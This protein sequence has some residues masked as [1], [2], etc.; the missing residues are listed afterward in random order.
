MMNA[1]SALDTLQNKAISECVNQFGQTPQ[2][3]SQ[4]PGRVNLIGEHVDYTGGLVLPIAINKWVLT[5]ICPSTRSRSRVY[6]ANSTCEYSFDACAPCKPVLSG[7]EMFAN[8]VMGVFEGI[9]RIQPITSQ[10][11]IAIIGDIPIGAGLSSSAAL[12]I[13]VIRA[14]AA[15]MNIDIDNLTAAHIA[16]DAEHDFVGT[17]CGIMDM[18]ISAAAREHHALLIDCRNLDTEFVELPPQNML[19]WTIVDTGISHTLA[20]SE[21]A[22]RR[23]SCLRVENTIGMTLREA[24][25]DVIRAKVDSTS[26]RKRGLHVVQENLRVTHAVSALKRC[27]LNAFGTILLEGHASLKE[28]YEVTVPE[29]DIIISSASSLRS[30][31]VYGARMTGGGFGGSVLIAHAPSVRDELIHAVERDFLNGTGRYPTVHH[32]HSTRGSD[33]ISLKT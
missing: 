30:R 16:M 21:Y 26:D 3:I 29:H 28:L 7:K 13:S 27:D 31:G 15:L 12:E 20:E 25:E 5:A 14:Y 2:I 8:H 22:L 17:P 9:R 19:E 24:T 11:D 23:E 4:A 6:S 10:Y 18:L 1:F 32:V 33:V